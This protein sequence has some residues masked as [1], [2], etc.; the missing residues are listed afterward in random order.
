MIWHCCE[1]WCRL[2][3]TAL[4]RLLAWEPP[5]AAGVALKKMTK[6]KTKQKSMFQKGLQELNS[7]AGGGTHSYYGQ[8]Y[9]EVFSFFLFFFFLGPHLRH[10]EVPRLGVELE[11]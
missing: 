3:A 1:L 11:L 9:L 8:S 5:Y 6:N 4:I 7:I 2:V 10:T